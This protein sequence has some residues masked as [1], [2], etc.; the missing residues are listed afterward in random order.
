MK[1][2]PLV[3]IYCMTYNH[4][5]FI[6][7]AMN[8]F[9]MQ[10]TDF[11]FVAIIVDDASTDGE[12][13]IIKRYLDEH[14]DMLNAHQWE[15]DDAYFIEA[16]NLKN[17]NCSFSVVLLKYNYYQQK[18]S[19]DTLFSLWGQDANYIAL[20]E[21]DDYW[22]AE[23]KLYKQV[24]FLKNHPE[25]GMS[26]TAFQTVDED[27][28]SISRDDY[29]Q[30]IL[31]SQTGDLLP[32]L[33]AS[34]FILTC[35]TVFR[36]SAYYQPWAQNLPFRHDYTIFLIA[37]ICGLC[38]FFPDKTSAYRK[39]STG[40]M[41]TQRSKINNMYH[42]TRLWAFDGLCSGKIPIDKKRFTSALKRYIVA[43]CI[44]QDNTE[45][46]NRYMDIIKENRFLWKYVPLAM[47]KKVYVTLKNS[48]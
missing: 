42:E 44:L 25:Y 7:D 48:F 10:K 12:Q 43:V 32:L 39:V 27:G 40:A 11:P 17:K 3:A 5:S 15:T 8:G 47:L 45:L 18:K 46:K 36:S 4:A 34:N 20:C 33:L 29:N 21:G 24:N 1:K 6:E 19:K 23:D 26:Y 22:I 13:D 31:H 2:E 9:C 30:M 14:F 41:A 28:H 38:K 16:K 37:S 35:T